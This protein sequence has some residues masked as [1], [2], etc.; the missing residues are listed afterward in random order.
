MNRRCFIALCIAFCTGCGPVADDRTADMLAGSVSEVIPSGAGELVRYDEQ[1]RR[2]YR[3]QVNSNHWAEGIELCF[4]YGQGPEGTER[5]ESVV[6]RAE[7]INR[8]RSVVTR[9][10]RLIDDHYVK[11]RLDNGQRVFTDLQ[12]T[13]RLRSGRVES[14][15]D[16]A[17]TV[18]RYYYQH[19]QRLP[20]K[21]VVSSSEGRQTF[22][23]EYPD[24]DSAGNWLTRLTLPEEG[25][26]LLESRM[27]KY[28]K[29]K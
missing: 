4:E 22:L 26:P 27:I 7:M 5:I 20:F 9:S 17:G 13:V 10:P 1:G 8:R 24:T 28:F 25:Q 6:R 21:A 19:N 11:I 18:T 3:A 15:T 29:R 23:Y 2:T 14:I 16:T 12:N